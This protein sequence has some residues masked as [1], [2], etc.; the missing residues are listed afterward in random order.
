MIE[1]LFHVGSFSISPFGLMLVLALG[2]AYWHLA[3]SMRYFDI[4]DEDDASAI[5]F[6]AGFIGILGAKIYYAVLYRDWHLLF[7]RAGIVFYGGFIAGLLAFLWIVRKRGLPM[8]RTFDVSTQGLA[9]AYGIGRIGCFLVGDDYGRPTDLPWG[10]AFPVGL[11][12]TTAGNLRGEF[13]VD[14]PPDVADHVLLAVHPTQLYEAGAGLLI[15]G[16]SLW[17]LMRR[18]PRP[19]TIALFVLALLAVERFLVELVRVKDDRFFGDFTLAQV[20]SVTLLV[21]LA[22]IAWRRRQRPAPAT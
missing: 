9:L 2:A 5:V 6:A 4:G 18:R 20:I 16:L 1:E 21:S 17:W 15:W 11:P 8:A 10:V 13:G 7:D 3:R 19:G 12:R 22:I 14:I